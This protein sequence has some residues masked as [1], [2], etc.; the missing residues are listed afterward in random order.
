MANMLALMGRAKVYAATFGCCR[1]FL[2]VGWGGSAVQCSWGQPCIEISHYLQKKNTL[3]GGGK[4]R[5]Q[6]HTLFL[7]S[8]QIAENGGECIVCKEESLGG[9]LGQAAQVTALDDR[10]SKP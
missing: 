9:Q 5:L 3:P 1:A 7:Q 2:E 6:K 4:W 10:T 8:R